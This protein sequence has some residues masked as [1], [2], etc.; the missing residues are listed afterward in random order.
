MRPALEFSAEGQSSIAVQR[1]AQAATRS[2]PRA[3]L[4]FRGS[5]LVDRGPSIRRGH[6]WALA[7]RVG[8][9]DLEHGLALALVLDLADH[10][11]LDLAPGL[12]PAA[13]HPQ[14]KRHV[15]SAL[16]RVDAADARSIPRPKKAR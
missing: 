16:L 10:R 7:G 6:P 15:R 14:A 13:L 11:A 8:L 3:G 5:S 4:Q 2:V 1:A 12:A 9:A